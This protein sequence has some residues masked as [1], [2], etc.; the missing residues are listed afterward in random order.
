MTW[1]ARPLTYRQATL[2]AELEKMGQLSD[3]EI[4]VK[5]YFW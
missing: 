1:L 3:I 2:L 5:L 4:Q